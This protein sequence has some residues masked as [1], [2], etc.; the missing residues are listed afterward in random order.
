M[1]AFGTR[2]AIFPYPGQ[3]TVNLYFDNFSLD[4]F[5]LLFY[6]NANASTKGL[7]ESLGFRNGEREDF[8]CGNHS[9]G[10]VLSKVLGHGYH[11]R[12]DIET[13][14]GEVKCRNPPIAMAVLPELGGPAMRIALPAILPSWIILTMRPAALRAL[15]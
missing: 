6:P 3:A 15:G 11:M 14:N 13:L 12:S 5:S 8:A 1:L 2:P 4:D 10:D 7:R 9:E